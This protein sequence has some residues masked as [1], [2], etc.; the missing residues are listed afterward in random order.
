MKARRART[1][2]STAI[3]ISWLAAGSVLGVASAPMASAATTAVHHGSVSRL[4]VSP[5]GLG[6]TRAA[7]PA[8]RHAAVRHAAV[9]RTAVRRTAVRRTAATTTLWVSNQI[10]VGNDS[11]CASPGFSTISS[12]ITAAG[13]SDATIK[14]CAGTYDEQLVI[15]QSV[16]LQA[17]GAVTV[18][19]PP[20]TPNPPTTCDGDGGASTPN[21]DIVHICGAISVTITGFTFQGSWDPMVCYDSI[22]GVAVLGGAS[23][24]MSKSTV[25]DVGGNPQTDGCQGG[26]GIEVGLALTGTTSDPGTATLTDD[27]VLNYQKNGITV[28]GKGSNAVINNA[29]VTGTGETPA[30]AQNGIQISDF[31]TAKINSGSVSGNEC[32]D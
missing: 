9:R 25:E 20:G 29:T 24:N 3:A 23:L 17:K 15:N 18:V 4:H 32:D 27:T 5:S 6:A 1:G 7:R 13:T 28:D 30:I 16:V 22:Y 31:A 19:A 2:I 21:Q 11:S 14:V 26:V 10:P 8:A 12:A